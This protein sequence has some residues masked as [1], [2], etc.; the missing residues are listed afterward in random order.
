MLDEHPNKTFKKKT[1]QEYWMNNVFVLE[2]I[3]KD[4]DKFERTF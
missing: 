4:H 3:I 2:N 1:F